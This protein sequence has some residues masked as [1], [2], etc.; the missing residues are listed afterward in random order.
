LDGTTANDDAAPGQPG[1]G[2]G[3]MEQLRALLFG[4]QM[5]DYERRLRALDERLG[6][7]VARLDDEQLARGDE[8]SAFARSELARLSAELRAE[9]EART[10]AQEQTADALEALR[11][12]LGARLDALGAALR[13]EAGNRD[14]ALLAQ[15]DALRETLDTRLAEVEQR[16]RA[17]GERLQDEKTGRDE[18]ARLFTELSSRLHRAPDLPG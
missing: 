7:E 8:V 15:A 2:D 18:L 6:A 17:D 9:R 3:N 11:G 5:R 14:A 1:A 4:S 10:A 13:D 16:L 12:D